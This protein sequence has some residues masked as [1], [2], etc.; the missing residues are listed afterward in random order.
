MDGWVTGSPLGDLE[1]PQEWGISDLKSFLGFL[2][3]SDFEVLF[4]IG[5]CPE[6]LGSPVEIPS[7]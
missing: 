4:S 3:S 1:L 2:H 5:N 7:V 6:E